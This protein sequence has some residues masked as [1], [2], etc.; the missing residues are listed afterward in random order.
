MDDLLYFKQTCYSFILPA[1]ATGIT[2]A[3]LTELMEIAPIKAVFSSYKDYSKNSTRIRQIDFAKFL[4]FCKN[5]T[6]FNFMSFTLVKFLTPF[7]ICLGVVGNILCLLVMIKKYRSKTKLKNFSLC[8]AMLCLA[9][10]T[11]VLFG[12]LREY[13]DEMF[14]I[15]IRAR[16][17]HLCRFFYFTCYLFS[18]FSS[19]LYAFIAWERWRAISDPLKHKRN[20]SLRNKRTIT[21]IFTFCI[22]ISLPFAYYPTLSESIKAERFEPLNVKL[23]VKCEIH[24]DGGVPLSLLDSV[25]FCFLPF[26]VSILFSILIFRLLFK[27]ERFKKKYIKSIFTLSSNTENKITQLESSK[28]GVNELTELNKDGLQDDL[29]EIIKH[30]SSNDFAFNK[31]VSAKKISNLKQTLLLVSFPISYLMANA[32]VFSMVTLKLIDYVF[33]LEIM[34]PNY[35]ILFVGAR[36]LM[37]T[38]S[39]INILLFILFGRIFRQDLVRLFVRKKALN[40]KKRYRSTKKRML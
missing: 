9:D 39:S 28:T 32:P 10:L 14:D 33:D 35:E 30:E 24:Q 5:L 13:V 8:L 23:D 4:Y 11:L 6:S 21:L 27:R 34:S 1:M 22:A 37:Y 36:I 38:N 40:V 20:Q 29:N 3:N 16:S 7:L 25:F 26:L 17:I 18:S 19:Y 31:T 15:S 12:C 2:Q